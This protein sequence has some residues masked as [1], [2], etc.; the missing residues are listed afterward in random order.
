MKSLSIRWQLFLLIACSVAVPVLF[1]VMY[2]PA[3]RIAGAEAALVRKATSFGHI[4]ADQSKSA[5]AFDDGQT[6]REIFDA[7]GTDADVTYVGL[8]RADG[9]QLHA[10]G[11]LGGPLSGA[12][13]TLV[14]SQHANRVRVVSP[15]VSLEGPRGS[16]VLELSMAQALKEG[17]EARFKALVVGLAALAFGFIAAWLVG[18]SFGRRVERVRAQ[19]LRVADGDLS[20][21]P[22][23]D[24]SSDEIGQLARGFKGMVHRLR[25][26]YDGV[27]QQVLDR[28]EALLASR[29]QYRALIETTEAVPWEMEVAT[30]CFTYVGPQAA[31]LLAVPECEWRDG[32]W[33]HH[34]MADDMEAIA[35][36]FAKAVAD[37]TQQAVEFRLRGTD[38]RQLWVRSLI[39]ARQED[40]VTILRGFMFD[41]TARAQLESEL[42]QAQ[43]LESV[44]LL[45]SGIAH[46]INTPVQFISDSVHFVR[47][48]F[49]DVNG[50]LN[51]YRNL[52]ALGDETTCRAELAELEQVERDSDLDYLME[53]VPTAL[54]RAIEGLGRVSTIVRSMKDFAHPDQQ[55][56]AAANVNNALAST[57]IIARNEYKDVADVET[58]FGE[59]PPVTCQIGELNQAFLNIIVNAAHATADAVSSGGVL[60]RGLIR[61]AT[62]QEGSEA[63]ITISDTGGGIP[64]H[65]R[66]K[67]FDP[68][69]TTKAVGRGTGQG[70]AMARRS[71][72]ERHG[73]SLTF[74]SVMGQGTTFT[75]RIP[76]VQAEA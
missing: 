40:T 34:V 59:L 71:V 55:G 3:S 44:G 57:L 56:K 76:I 43:K 49:V 67:I 5:I 37:R 62:Q 48:S 18:S 64:D 25:H 51:R 10:L 31:A 30:R 19:A 66:G 4:L 50:L 13:N 20:D 2:F 29:E 65:V 7:I 14:V 11:T 6:A 1:L 21:P 17:A 33:Q 39:S 24:D 46:E 70:L 27:E 68:F 73:G 75:I 60:K 32:S 72:V 28:T 63:V 54:D 16:L 74:D 36:G 9:S 15:V 45:A 23:S 47:D 22:L 35:A 69:F 38:G 52:R 61:V 8:L 12:G 58:S 42:R 53:N 26:A 41:V